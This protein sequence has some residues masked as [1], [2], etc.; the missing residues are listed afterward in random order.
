M[1]TKL[2]P[3]VAPEKKLSFRFSQRIPLS[4]FP[5]QANFDGKVLRPSSAPTCRRLISLM[6]NEEPI[7]G[8]RN[9]PLKIV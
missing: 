6:D 3:S 8:K 4:S 7:F 1:L 5:S 2:I 9:F